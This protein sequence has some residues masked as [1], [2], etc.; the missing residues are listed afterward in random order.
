MEIVAAVLAT[1]LVAAGETPTT[2]PAED[3]D[4]LVAIARARNREVLEA[5]ALAEAAHARIRPAGSLDDPTLAIGYQ[6]DNASNFPTL[7]REV[8]SQIFLEVE[9]MFPGPGKRPLRREIAHHLWEHAAAE[10]EAVA[11]KVEADVRR[12]YWEI[13]RIDVEREVLER[14]RENL[15][16]IAAGAESRYS[17]GEGIQE[18]VLRAG[19]EVSMTTERLRMLEAERRGAVATLN[20][21]LD[22]PPD[23]PF[24]RPVEASTHDLPGLGE[25]E[26]WA[27]DSCPVIVGL[28][29]RVMH[30]EAAV[31]LAEAERRPDWG[32][33][34][35]VMP[36]GSLPTMFRVGI[37]ITLP[38]RQRDRQD[39]WVRE[40][41]ANLEAAEQGL[42]GHWRAI[43]SR[44]EEA[45]ARAESA[46]DLVALYD[47][48]IIPQA[49]LALRSSLAGYQV[50]RVDFMTVVANVVALRQYEVERA[51]RLAEFHQAVAELESIVA[52]PLRP[53]EVK[54]S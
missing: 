44:M 35:G 29:Y 10:A 50:G 36:R 43:R 31:R 22:R 40:A 6:E 54:E 2:E 26:S 49:S 14:T 11:L 41:R 23:V 51:R 28:Q 37:K 53:K 16:A 7:G 32:V 42:E 1:F 30:E 19:L 18:D 25:M 21:L 24:G 13:Y 48:S 34:G 20:A 9:Q 27:R 45:V 33:M 52:R 47:S 15:R 3:L 39:E 8:M 38:I 46:R 17:V 12:A 5:R 4:A